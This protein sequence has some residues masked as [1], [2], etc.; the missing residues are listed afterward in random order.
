MV[1]CFSFSNLLYNSKTSNISNINLMSFG[2]IKM[3]GCALYSSNNKKK[4]STFKKQFGISE[5]LAGD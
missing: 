2:S 4:T 1:E 3:H 5:A